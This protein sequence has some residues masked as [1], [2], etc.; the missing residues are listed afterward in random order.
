MLK[1]I[2]FAVPLC[3]SLTGCSGD[4]DTALDDASEQQSTTPTTPADSPTG[5]CTP[6]KVFDEN[7]E[8]QVVAYDENG[9]ECVNE[10]THVECGQILGNSLAAALDA[11]PPDQVLHLVIGVNDLVE[12]REG[13]YYSASVSPDG[14]VT[15]NGEPATMEEL[16]ALQEQE[17]QIRQE[18]QAERAAV[19]AKLYTELAR[20]EGWVVTQAEIDQFANGYE[21]IHRDI[22]AGDIPRFVYDNCDIVAYVDLYCEG[23]DE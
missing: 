1:H 20:R 16:L 19:R 10:E 14:T 23:Q 2:L 8:I 11:V 6:V 4:A 17:E 22:V 5:T 13:P 21:S 18:I 7:G 3:A 15:I 9:N 12:E